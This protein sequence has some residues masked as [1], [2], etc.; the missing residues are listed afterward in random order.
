MKGC[1]GRLEVFFI[2]VFVIFCIY[3]YLVKE[4]LF[5]LVKGR[6]IEF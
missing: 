2:Y 1:K 4:I 3:M 6:V 5:L